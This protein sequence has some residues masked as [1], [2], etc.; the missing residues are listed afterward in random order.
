MP[1][2]KLYVEGGGNNNH[3]L[4]TACRRGFSQFLEKAGLAGRMPRIVAC[5]SRDDAYKSFCTA[6]RQNRDELPLLLVDSEAIVAADDGSWQHLQRRDNWQR[7]TNTSDDH[8]H[9]M[10]QCME[11]WFIADTDTLASYYGDGFNRNSLPRHANLEAVSKEEIYRSLENSTR[12]TSKG[13]YSKGN[14]SFE[15]LGRVDPVSVRGRCTYAERFIL[16]LLETL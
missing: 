6:L 7:P 16:F 1:T 14:H 2:V 5:G 9:L 15:I 8:A 11:T 13:S 12:Q 3:A 10:A 4:R